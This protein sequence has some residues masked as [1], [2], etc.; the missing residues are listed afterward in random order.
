MDERIEEL[1][2]RS[3]NFGFLLPHEPL[4]VLT[5]VRAESY[6]YSDPNTALYKAR[7]F[8]EFLARKLV[9]LTNTAVHG[10]AQAVR[11]AALTQ[12]GALVP[13][14][15]QAFDRLRAVGNVAV[16]EYYGEVRAALEGVRTCFELG[17]WF[18]RAV[19]G[20]REP[21]GFV[22]PP[23]P[24]GHAREPVDAA[25]RSDLV[26]LQA[27]LA[28][29]QERLA[30]VKLR[31]DGKTARQE[32]EARARAEAEQQLAR[33]L[34]D[35]DALRALTDQL[36]TRL[37]EFESAFAVETAQP[38]RVSA[39]DRELLIE[40]ARA[41]ATEPRTEA[42]V[43][44]EV[45][46]LLA[47]AGWVL[48]D[49]G[50]ENLF[51]GVGVAV[52]EA[53]TAAGTADYLLYVH[54][55]L[56]GVIEAKREGR[57]LTPVERQSARY[58]EGLTSAQRLQAWRLPLPFR[59]E[60]TAA[61][62]HF[63][64][65]LDP[66]SRGRPVFSFHRPETLDRWMREAEADEHAPTLRARLRRGLP[67]LDD[68]RLREAQREAVTGL[69]E[70]LRR[71]RPR[72]LIQMA[73]GAGKTFAAVSSSYRLLK[74]AKAERVLFL[75][76]RNNLGKQALTEFHNYV[77]PDDG[78]KFAELYNVQ[79]LTGADMLS[80]SMVVISTVQRLY[81]MLR[82]QPI[83]DS[84]TD[85]EA[86]DAYG[87]DEIID[88]SY[89]PDV[90]PETFDLIIVDECHRSIYGRWRAVLEYFDAYIVGLT[91]TPVKQTF[92]FF[93]QNL[94]SEY[95]YEQAVADGVNVQFDVY[96]IR[97][98]V[99]EHGATIDAGT[100]V[101]KRDLRTRRQ[102]Y[103]ELDED[104]GYTGAQLGGKVVSGPQLR[105]VLET[106]RD[107][108]F[109]EIF[110]KLPGQPPR[111]YVP[112]TL[113]YASKDNHAEDIVQLVREIFDQGN[114]FAAKITYSAANPDQ[115]LAAF[116]NSPE[117]RIAVTVDMIATGTDVRPLECV[118]FLRDVK[119]WSYFEQMKGRGAR[120]LDPAELRAVTPD[121]ASKD[122]F[123][124]VDAVGVTD[125]PRVDAAP[126]QR[127]TEKQ[128]SFE[129]LL[130]K[131]GTLTITLGE[132]STLG[133]R[134]AALDRQIT[135]EQRVE[136]EG[137][138][139]QPLNQVIGSVLRV[140][141][142][143]ELARLP[144]G[145]E[146]A[147]RSLVEDAVRP[148]AENP[149]LRRRLLEIRRQRDVIYD[150]VNPDRLIE[151]RGLTTGEIAQRTVTSFHD[152]VE[153]HRDEITA[154]ELAY[155][156]GDGGRGVYLQLKDL[157]TRIARPPH[158]WTPETLWRAYEEL[159]L[160]AGRH[161]VTYG[162]VDLIG[163]IRYEL[164]LDQH[165]RPHRS[166]V[167]ERFENWLARQH[168]SGV[169]FAADQI[170]WLEGIRDIVATSAGFSHDDLDGVPFSQRGGTD[171]F[172][173]T[174]GTAH[175]ERILTDL[176]RGLTA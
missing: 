27:E 94:V 66:V 139:G 67:A 72:A 107:N 99:S 158:Q 118:F 110:P 87:G 114:T 62:T 175:A 84:D 127:H 162:A 14:V 102:R 125:S 58:A 144:V 43:R 76:D 132:T 149:E 46:R 6:V 131:A 147:I 19:T 85:D 146:Q 60:T 91:A 33:A 106:F 37:A 123:V 80:S 172:I 18:H 152:Y 65:D 68:G 2:R 150:E 74:H 89:N 174:F 163:L 54:R 44:R 128:V 45:D 56:I 95:S 117:L 160:A 143:D 155:R 129:Q 82:G 42:E 96:R 79:R 16:H 121:A 148:L 116:R 36:N 70:S 23:E 133:G 170:W 78:R 40:N 8:G 61:E 140:A 100:V 51:A 115:L 77:T 55:K 34:A 63:T 13:Q 101:P 135:P 137:I 93:H 112:K 130:R 52:R 97:T 20:D 71:D 31:L 166:V 50:R 138:A 165:P 161:G 49:A 86:Y 108:L 47:A 90:P 12:A 92:G 176:N 171:G 136:L 17:V 59:Y 38:M 35:R 173:R 164:G 41:A 151:A 157:A 57:I 26:E 126:L 28:R 24:D 22:P 7:Q 64:N 104:F 88:V 159:G 39:A 29:Y 11:L 30:E 81:A 122:R 156:L 15:G 169:E 111:E 1:A 153:Q 124:I 4:L 154:I 98:E 141:D 69:E 9:S 109:T 53:A 10:D 113:I 119:S 142:T 32:A 168:Q 21:I 105:L 3:P 120:T 167:E 5:G 145:D 73:T 134:L 83:P 103:E 25:D 75:V 48:Q